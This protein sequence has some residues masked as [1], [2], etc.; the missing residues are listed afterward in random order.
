MSER[1]AIV[2]GAGLGGLAAAAALRRRGWA[3]HM[4]EKG[5]WPGP[6][7]SGLAMMPNALRALDAFGV[8]DTVRGLAAIQGDGGLRRADGRYLARTSAAAVQARFGDPMV[9][10]ERARLAAI[11]RDA[12]ADVP[13]HS[14]APAVVVD[15]GDAERAAV[16]RTSEGD[17]DAELIVA[18]DGV[19]SAARAELFP[20]HP[21]LRQTGWTAWRF[22]VAASAAVQ[23]GETWGGAGVVGLVPLA[24]DRTYFYAAAVA[25]VGQRAADDERAELLRRFG[26]WHAPIRQLIESSVPDAV[27]RGDIAE[28]AAPLPALHRGRVALLGDAA[29]PMAPFLGQ[30][31]CQAIED[32]VVLAHALDGPDGLVGYT[33]ARRGR[34]ADVVRRSHRMG[35]LALLRSPVARTLRD[36][37][38]RTVGSLSSDTAI[39]E[40]IPVVDWRP[41]MA[42]GAVVSG[43]QPDPR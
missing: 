26:D 15:A 16:V 6:A 38:L 24:D 4:Y 10:L 1:R 35:A 33:A 34:T 22:I 18:A 43:V 13:L 25:P 23:T 7:G 32:A 2:I 41:P 30:G 11:L 40:L 14:G 39:R 12:A 3:V 31:A 5:P 17:E 37:F 19:H 9:V 29:H 36:T 27:L 28:L 20:E 8:G 21:G 42:D